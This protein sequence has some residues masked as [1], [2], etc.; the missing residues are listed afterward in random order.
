[1]IKR[2]DVHRLW[3]ATL[4]APTR[5]VRLEAPGSFA[6]LGGISG[7]DLGAQ[8]GDRILVPAGRY[9]HLD[10]YG[11]HGRPDAWISFEAADLDDPPVIDARETIRNGIDIQ[12]CSFVALF[13]FRIVGAVDGRNPDS[14]GVAVFRGSKAVRVWS[15]DVRNFPGGGINCFYT[16]ATDWEGTRLPAGGWDGVDVAFN[17]ISGCCRRSAYNTS[18][19]SFFGAEHLEGAEMPEAFGYRALHNT[20]E[21]CECDVP[22]S[23]GG[24]DFVTDGNG[25]SVDCL[26]RRNSL[27]PALPSYR[28]LGRVVGNLVQR[29][30]GRGLHVLDSGNLEHEGNVYIG[31]LRTLSP[32]F[33]GAAE[34]EVSA[35]VDEADVSGVVHRNNVVIPRLGRLDIAG[36]GQTT[37]DLMAPG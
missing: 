32:A 20:I 14:S 29:N 11:L 28:K 5:T 34:V 18:G 31:N 36:P 24:F 35:S 33:E 13:G 10:L 3:S 9:S 1:M 12:Q 26:A 19:I 37:H 25:I 8:A 2:R 22:Y 4:P 23:I 27:T 15:C 21:D 6:P 7:G 30:G 16:S 17:H